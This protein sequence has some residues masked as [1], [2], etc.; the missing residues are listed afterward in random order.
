MAKMLSAIALI[1]ATAA[2]AFAQAYVE[3]VPWFQTKE[4]IRL[5]ENWV[6]SDSN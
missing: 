2:P 3:P 1:L 6:D 4:E 5:Y